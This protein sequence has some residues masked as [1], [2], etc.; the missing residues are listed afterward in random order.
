MYY[1]F[2]NYDNTIG[3]QLP[4]ILPSR[5]RIYLPKSATFTNNLS[6]MILYEPTMKK[7]QSHYSHQKRFHH[8][9][10]P[11]S[12]SSSSIASSVSSMEDLVVTPTSNDHWFDPQQQHYYY[13]TA[14][15]FKH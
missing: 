14:N 5:D 7:S 12:T 13:P 3:L 4:P 9:N 6:N 15:L 11:A 10:I 1:T 8:Y 2:I